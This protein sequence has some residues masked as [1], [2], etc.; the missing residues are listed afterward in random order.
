M[1]EIILTPIE[2]DI[3]DHLSDTL[4]TLD[5]I[6]PSVHKSFGIKTA[7]AS[8]RWKEINGSEF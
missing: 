6:S 3:A 5:I 1:G 8:G 2:E 7:D 4:Q